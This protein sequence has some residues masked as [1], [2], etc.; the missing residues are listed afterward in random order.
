VA[1]G[2]CPKIAQKVIL[3]NRSDVI[4]LGTLSGELASAISV[5]EGDR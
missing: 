1:G 2:V 3:E 5:E 4:E